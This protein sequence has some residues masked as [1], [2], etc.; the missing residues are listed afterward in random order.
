MMQIIDARKSFTAAELAERFDVSVRTIQ[1]DLAYL[2]Q[3]G[4]PLYAKTGPGGGYRALPNRLLP[5]LRLTLHEALGLFL[6]LQVLERIP[7]FPFGSIRSHLAE[8]YYGSLP[9]DVR[10][11]LDRLRRHT[12]IRSPEPQLPAPLTTRLLEAA[13]ERSR[14]VF[15]YE[16]PSGERQ[17]EGYP[18]GIYYE[19]GRWY[20]PLALPER[21]LL[22]R[23][24]RVAELIAVEPGEPD[25]ATLPTLEQW[26]QTPPAREGLRVRLQFTAAGIRDASSDPLLKP[27]T[28]DGIW[29]DWVPETEL[30]Y[31]SR[32]LLRYGPE[33]RVLEPERLRTMMIEHYRRS[34][35]HY[36]P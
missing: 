6:L 19:H 13:M 3:L 9:P 7:D 32:L 5:P 30:E 17:S 29:E 1:R 28:N 31:T 33:V 24:D 35:S 12:A 15:R 2:Q 10:D 26:L 14:I 11:T 21:T 27:R 36:E 34:L 4:F 20:M 8:Q 16:G 18:L 22:Y 25:A 23:V